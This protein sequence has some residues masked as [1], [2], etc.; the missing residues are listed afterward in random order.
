MKLVR[1]RKG[2]KVG[3]GILKKRRIQKVEGKITGD[4]QVLDEYYTLSD[5]ELL[6]P[7]SPSKVICVGL[8]YKDHAQELGMEL[9]TEPIIFLKPATTVIGPE[10][11][12]KY[13]KMS[14]QV[15]YEAELAVVIKDQIKNITPDQAQEHILGYTCAND[16]TA[17]DLQRQDGQWTRAKSFDTFAPLG[18]VIETELAPDSL[19]IELFKNGELKQ[20]SNTAKMI[21]SIPKLVSFISQVMSLQPGDVILTGTPPG[22]GAVDLEDQIEVKIE[23]IGTLKN[24]IG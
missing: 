1:F 16:V 13:P 11:I 20:T 23:G 12:I 5:V 9:P 3:Y 24:K 10:D 6:A 18:P 21:F 15:D 8:N 17:R 14:Q 4:Y 22:V 19:K 2:E 7:C